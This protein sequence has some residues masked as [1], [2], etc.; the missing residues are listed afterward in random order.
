M[1]RPCIS[2]IIPC[3]NME[4]YV[5]ESLDSLCC[6]TLQ[7][8]EA[9]CID[10]GS[11]D[12]TGQILDW[13][14]E[15]D[16]RIKV[17]HQS[18]KGVAA[19]RNKGLEMAEGQFVAFLDPDD[20]YPDP[21]TLSLLYHKAVEH[22]ALI[23]GGSFSNYNNETG[24]VRTYFAG[25]YAQYTFRTEG[26]VEYADYQFDFGY[27]RF[28][29]DR[30]FLKKNG[31]D[32]PLYIR[33][34][35]PPFFVRAMIAA[36]RFYAV[37]D[38]VYRYRKGIQV[39]ATTWAEPKLHDMMRGYRDVFLLSA[40]HRLETLHALTL[41]RF[42][43]DSVFIPVMNSLRRGNSGT[44][45]L[46]QEIKEAIDV[47]LLRKS[48][49]RVRGETY[50]LRH[51]KERKRPAAVSRVIARCSKLRMSVSVTV[52]DCMEYGPVH[53]WRVITE[54]LMR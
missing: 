34:Q 43:E 11:T 35:D 5:K 47:S 50:T 25:D 19:A 15:T 54:K 52:R 4:Q 41:R 49:V 42:E 18:N 7:E 29:Y 46:L 44:E 17:F 1:S 36:Q 48:G 23:C 33:Y 3:Y 39:N 30:K 22:E 37:P 28:L 24:K 32:F 45:A 51:E 13:Y 40:E 14:Q 12:R 16:A 27:H 53:T 26:L 9:I 20:F 10:D 8:I 21:D 2:V 38:V 6:Q 31:I